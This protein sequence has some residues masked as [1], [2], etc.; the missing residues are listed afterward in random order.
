MCRRLFL[1]IGL[2]AAATNVQ[3]G[4]KIIPYLIQAP[5]FRT[6]ITITNLCDFPASYR[7]DFKGSDGEW[8]K[9]AWPDG[10]LWSAV[11][12]D[13]DPRQSYSVR[14]ESQSELR[15]G[16]GE[17]TDDS[18][19]C[20]VFEV[21]YG[22]TLPDG[23]SE[24]QGPILPRKLSETGV[25]TVFF[26]S[27]V[28]DTSIAIAGNGG[29]VSLEELNW[30]GELLAREEIENVHHEA[31]TVKDVFPFEETTLGWLDIKGNVDVV[32]M[33]MC[34]EK[35]ANAP[36]VHPLPTTVQYEVVGFET[37]H[38]ERDWIESRLYGHKYAYRLTIRNPTQKDLSYEA[39]A[40]CRDQEGFVLARTD[41]IVENNVFEPRRKFPVQA[42]QT[43]TFEGTIDKYL[44]FETDPS[45]VTV[46]VA[47]EVWIPWWEY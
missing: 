16:Y 43:K 15:Q 32:A 38:L 8:V 39:E 33:W 11:R 20:V 30:S 3:A 27:D 6:W 44:K 13:M 37:R 28:C 12:D 19:V 41:I 17:I 21:Y 10:K 4:N 7:I 40:I 9:F 47:V 25:S 46:E 1:M 14:L 42:G 34:D 24:R 26:V 22:Q 31:F 5:E 35:M 29:D 23:S 18:G 36:V 45:E 2:W